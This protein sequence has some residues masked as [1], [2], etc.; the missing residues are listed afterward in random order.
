MDEKQLPEEAWN[1][2]MNTSIE[3]PLFGYDFDLNAEY[4]RT[5]FKN[6]IIMDME[7]SQTEMHIYN[8]KG[9]SYSNS[10]QVDVSV[11]PVIG[12]IFT[13]A[14]RLNDVKM[15]IN[16]QLVDKP[17]QSRTKGFFNV[18]Y[19]TENNGWSADFTAEYNGSGRIFHL[20]SI[21][22]EN[23]IENW[24]STF[25]AFVLLHAQIT[26]RFKNFD[27]YLGGE[28]LTDYKQKE[29]ILSFNNPRGAYFEAA[30]IWGP[31]LGRVIYLG[32]R[33][34]IK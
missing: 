7:K 32:I 18:S 26:K 34:T 28:N 17:L 14:Y 30:M 6:Q 23:N 25:P 33:Y 16:G 8:L 11:E 20:D 15:N 4:Y 10:F 21:P 5:D 24:G 12:L 2:G 22:P 27:V 3:I 19:S 29:T 1:Y 31:T 9:K 13:A